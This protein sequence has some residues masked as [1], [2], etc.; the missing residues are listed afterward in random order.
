MLKPTYDVIIQVSLLFPEMNV[1]FAEP[2]P[3]KTF[4][5]IEEKYRIR[6]IPDI[7]CDNSFLM[8]RI[9]HS[10]LYSKADFFEYLDSFLRQMQLKVAYS[11][12]EENGFSDS[13]EEMKKRIED[14]KKLDG[15]IKK[16]MV[17]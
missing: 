5:A 7:E 3:E 16:L 17:E 15:K 12:T 14:R 1:E 6:V 11:N 4:E 13:F 10:M 8:F 2:K 9:K